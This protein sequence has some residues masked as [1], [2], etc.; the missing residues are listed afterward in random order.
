[1]S[2]AGVNTRYH[3]NAAP[4]LHS[5]DILDGVWNNILNTIIQYVDHKLSWKWKRNSLFNSNV[6]CTQPRLFPSWSIILFSCVQLSL[7][8]SFVRGL[9]SQSV[10]FIKVS[11]LLGCWRRLTSG[12]FNYP[13]G[14]IPVTWYRLRCGWGKSSH[15]EQ[16]SPILHQCTFLQRV[17]HG[18]VIECTECYDN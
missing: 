9:M 10:K 7:S 18:N 3:R 11:W 17:D 13:K 15:V 1:M 2:S 8:A 6:K 5:N 14:A 16:P 4:S 12:N